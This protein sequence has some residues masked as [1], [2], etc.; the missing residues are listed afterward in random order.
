MAISAYCD[1]CKRYTLFTL[2]ADDFF[3]CQECGKSQRFYCEC[4][5]IAIYKCDGKMTCHK[6]LEKKG[7][8][9][10]INQ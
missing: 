6:C 10:K 3:D 8:N 2:E 7:R 1:K 9:A 5:N 4:G